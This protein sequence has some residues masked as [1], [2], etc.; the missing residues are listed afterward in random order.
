MRIGT[1]SVHHA[2]DYSLPPVLEIEPGQRVELDL[3][4]SSGGQLGPESTVADVA[5]LDFARVNPVTGPIAVRGAQPGD[6]V[7]I[8]VV[9][10]AVDSWGWTACIPGFGLLA[11]EFTDAHL[12]ISS[13]SN[14]EIALPFGPVLPAVP[15]IGTLGLALPEPGAH[16]LVPPSRHGGNLDIR[17]LTEGATI[18]LPVG[19]PG[20]LLSAGDAHAAMGDGEVCGTGIETSAR[21]VLEIGLL[22]GAAP[23][24]PIL[25]TA[26]AANRPGPALATT[27]VGPDLMTAAKDATKA[28]IDEIVRRTGLAPVDAYLLASVSADLKISEI[29]DLPNWVVSMHVPLALLNA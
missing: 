21:T 9:E 8:R 2:W 17:H 11:D 25:E 19:V 14:N 24:F 3:M 4:N 7:T 10:L 22:P 13:I 5:A 12:A 27:G 23:R 18:T 6:A 29:V 15:M 26:P 1:E 28:M 20:A 16:S